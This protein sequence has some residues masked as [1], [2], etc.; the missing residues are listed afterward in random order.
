MSFMTER[1]H[2]GRF[3]PYPR[4]SSPCQDSGYGGKEDYQSAFPPPEPHS[5]PPSPHRPLPSVLSMPPPPFH[6]LAPVPASNS[7]ANASTSATKN[8]AD[9]EES[10]E[11]AR[12]PHASPASTCTTTNTEKQPWLLI[13][14]GIPCSGKTSFA[15]KLVNEGDNWTWINQDSLGSRRACEFSV[16]EALLW[17]RNV[18][19]DRSNF[20]EAQREHWIRIAQ[21]QK[22]PVRVHAIFFDVPREVCLQRIKLR[23]GHPTLSAHDPELENVLSFFADSL[24]PPRRSEGLET[25]SYI[26][27][28]KK[29][30]VQDSTDVLKAFVTKSFQVSEASTIYDEAQDAAMG[31]QKGFDSPPESFDEGDDME[32]GGEGEGAGA[33]KEKRLTESLPAKFQQSA[34]YQPLV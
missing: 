6:S 1:N 11:T 29:S 7:T 16:F 4:H 13:L 5:L 28:E 21:Q 12:T 3:H 32:G 31:D 26:R 24:R 23:H 10:Y 25:V 34:A 20:D 8:P 9:G 2:S 30:L 27:Y 33:E 19:V 15:Q 22:T 18:V 17:G 14:V